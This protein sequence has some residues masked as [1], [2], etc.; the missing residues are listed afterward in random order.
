MPL[1][2]SKCVQKKAPK[3]LVSGPWL[4]IVFSDYCFQLYANFYAN[5]EKYV[6]LSAMEENPSLMNTVCKFE[7]PRTSYWDCFLKL[8]FQRWRNTVLFKFF[9]RSFSYCFTIAM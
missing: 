4:G 9:P 3:N 2:E 6:N 7:S 1:T 5:T 8:H